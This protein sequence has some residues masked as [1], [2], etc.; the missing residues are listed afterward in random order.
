MALPSQVNTRESQAFVDMGPGK[1]AKRIQIS[2][3]NGDSIVNENG[4]LKVVLDGA[5]CSCNSS[6]TP[7]LADAF[8]QGSAADTL[9][10]AMIFVSVHS[11]VA[12]AID[13]LYVEISHDSVTWFEGD[14]YTIPA[15]VAKTFSL[16]PNWKYFRIKYTNG[17]TEQGT[18]VLHTLFKKGN[19]KPSSHR[20]KDSISGDDDATLQK[21]V[22]TAKDPDGVFVNIQATHS[23]NLKVA[24]VEDGLSI[25]KGDV[26]GTTFIHK[27]GDAPDFDVTDGYVNIWDG[28][29]DGD[30]NSMVYTY[31]T[32]ADIDSLACEGADT[33]D[34]EIQGLDAN[35]DLLIQTVTATGTT[36]VAIPIPL[37]RVFR[38]KNV[39]TVDNA[40][41][42]NVFVNDTMVT[43][44]GRPDTITNLRANIHPGNNQTL[45]A[46]YTIPNG[47]T[48]YLRDLFC[49]LSGAKRSSSHILRVE[50]RPFGQVFQLKY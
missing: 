19:S 11:D 35:Y 50:A 49:S 8:F 22:L 10:Y 18:F 6:T 32:T 26:I 28:A 16:Q 42:V 21:S 17:G 34:Y 47:K 13:G 41:N 30:I 3:S 45:M 29:D 44:P 39:G 12:S 37:I 46:L 1:T 31:S 36:R 15:G 24:N 25:A 20:I 2:D 33:S 5:V 27:F 40:N 4:Q 14:R 23:D 38:I 7:L 43:V 9:D 48:G